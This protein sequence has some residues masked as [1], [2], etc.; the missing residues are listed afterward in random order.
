MDV[1]LHKYDRYRSELHDKLLV[2]AQACSKNA[3]SHKENQETWS[4]LEILEHLYLVERKFLKTIQKHLDAH[5][6]Y[7]HLG[8]AGDL[9]LL[10]LRCALWLPLKVKVPID[11]VKPSGSREFDQL[12]TDWQD[13]SEEWRALLDG[14]KPELSTIVVMKHPIAGSLR[15]DHCISF[16]HSHLTHHFPQ[17]ANAC[18]GESAA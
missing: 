8:L 10:L 14:F 11:S 12:V 15:I 13:V 2:P 6:S 4:P 17:W 1:L 7:K 3:L 16:L 5:G 9:R 18:R